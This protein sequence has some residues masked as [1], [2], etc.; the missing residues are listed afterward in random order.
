MSK[1]NGIL[2]KILMLALA[3]ILGIAGWMLSQYGF[4]SIQS[5]RQIERIPQ[6]SIASALQGEVKLNAQVKKRNKLIRSEHF[7]VPC[8][9]YFYRLE[10]EKRDSD[11]DT[12]WSTEHESTGSV[13]FFLQDSTGRLKI[14]IQTLVDDKMD[15]SMPITQQREVGDYRYT[16]WRIESDD[17]LFVLGM[18]Q[19]VGDS[20]E[21][22]FIEQ[23]QY[24]PLISKYG[25]SEEKSDLGMTV[26]LT[27]C[28]GISLIAFAAFCLISG[29][30]IHR[31]LVFLFVLS[32]ST[33]IPLVQ[34]GLSMLHTDIVTG[35]ERLNRLSE[36]SL[37]KINQSIHDIAR[38]QTNWPDL[39]ERLRQMEDRLEV[40]QR[41]IV[42]DIQINLAFAQQQ[43]IN[44]LKVFPNN[45]I[46]WIYSVEADNITNLLNQQ[47]SAALNLRL[48]NFKPARA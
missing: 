29:L 33:I 10:R 40:K 47:Q 27:V 48:K 4:N 36:I 39:S 23:G 42:D 16:E 46:A 26:I 24:L 45:L 35:Q 34:L 31:I 2:R 13:D 20:A 1:K 15:Y 19:G 22:G 37:N 14:N 5:L 43:Y 38:P 11:G 41:Q 44:Q 30:S 9:Y 25:E 12:Y 6:T 21:L 32:F 7:N 18:L 8:V 28:G 3:L 17:Q